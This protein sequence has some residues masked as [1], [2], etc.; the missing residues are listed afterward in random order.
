MGFCGNPECPG[1]V[2]D[3]YM[4]DFDADIPRETEVHV[5]EFITRNSCVNCHKQFTPI[6]DMTEN[7][8]VMHPKMNGL[9][10]TCHVLVNNP[11]K[12]RRVQVKLQAKIVSPQ[13]HHKT[14]EIVGY[15]ISLKIG[16]DR[17]LIHTTVSKEAI[18]DFE[19]L[20]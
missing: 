13:R 20:K 18:V 9:C 19:L 4:C 8:C 6:T 15:N 10:L 14:G 16:R 11:N 17:P 2:D 12:G 3:A 5:I 1:H 7:R